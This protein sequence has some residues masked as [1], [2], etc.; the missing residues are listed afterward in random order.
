MIAN[1]AALVS[2]FF[3]GLLISIAVFEI[4]RKVIG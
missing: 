4:A 3:L 1:I 2:G